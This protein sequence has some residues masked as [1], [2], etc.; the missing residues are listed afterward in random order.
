MIEETSGRHLG[1]VWE[2]SGRH[3]GGWRLRRHMGGIWK[4]DLIKLDSLSNRIHIFL[5]KF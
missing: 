5:L 2:A 4:A 3:L 1:G